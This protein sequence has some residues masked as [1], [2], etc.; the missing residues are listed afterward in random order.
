MSEGGEGRTGAFHS[1]DTKEKIAIRSRGK[2]N[3]RYINKIYTFINHHTL[4][5]FIGTKND[6]MKKLNIGNENSSI[7]RIVNKQ[8]RSYK[9][10]TLKN[11]TIP[12]KDFKGKN[13]PMFGK[14]DENNPK[15]D[16]T[17]Y[18][19]QKETTIEKCNKFE[20]SRKYG[21]NVK[22]INR[23]IKGERNITL[24]WIFLGVA[25]TTP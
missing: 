13:N 16:K 15:S 14:Y 25:E 12:T 8:D 1:E 11:N 2:N 17:I 23:I 18:L 3:P 6:L 10:W 21:I 22:Y 9:G 7:Y 19:F 5:E 4:E 24:G 20:L